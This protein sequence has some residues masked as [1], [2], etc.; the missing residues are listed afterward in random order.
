MSVDNELRIDSASQRAYNHYKLEKVV[1]PF[2]TEIGGKTGVAYVNQSRA[3]KSIPASFVLAYY[4]HDW[5][6]N[7]QKK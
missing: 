2:C 6:L 4:T 3:D 5:R 7:D 1:F